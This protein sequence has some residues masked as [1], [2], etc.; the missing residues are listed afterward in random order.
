MSCES[1]GEMDL[2]RTGDAFAEKLSDRLPHQRPAAERIINYFSRIEYV[3]RDLVA[4]GKLRGRWADHTSRVASSRMSRKVPSLIVA[5]AE[6]R[7]MA[8]EI[9]GRSSALCIDISVGR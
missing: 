4:S 7:T 9:I 3:G 2:T 6:A 8:R 5:G 1:C